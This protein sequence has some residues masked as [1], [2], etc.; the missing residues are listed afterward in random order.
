MDAEEKGFLSALKKDPNDA[1]ARG[2]YA[3]WL[4]EHGRAHEAMLQRA[5]AGLSEI[6]YKIRRTS[7]GLFSEGA[8]GHHEGNRPWTTRGTASVSPPS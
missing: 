6:R 5:S 2:A 3:D 4:D 8:E 1:T 7:D